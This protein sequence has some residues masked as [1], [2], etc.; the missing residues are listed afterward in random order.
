MN[1]QPKPIRPLVSPETM[2]KIVSTQHSI[3]PEEFYEEVAKHTGKPTRSAR[4]LVLRN[5]RKIWVSS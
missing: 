3:S 4:K 2:E 5:G 1:P